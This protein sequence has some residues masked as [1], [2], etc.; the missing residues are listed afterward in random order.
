MEKIVIATNQLEPDQVLL[1]L[2]KL[3][4]L[5]PNCGIHFVVLKGEA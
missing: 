3:N 5:F 4:M 2:L 1:V